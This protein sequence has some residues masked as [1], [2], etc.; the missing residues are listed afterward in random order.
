VDDGEYIIG[1]EKSDDGSLIVSKQHK[2]Y[3]VSFTGDV[4]D[5][6][7]VKAISGQTGALSHWSMVQI[8]EGVFYLSERGPQVVVG[9]ESHPLAQTAGIL[10]MFEFG[11]STGFNISSLFYST[12]VNDTAR[13]TLFVTV[14]SNGSTLRDQ[15]LC[16][17]YE[18]GAFHLRDGYNANFLAN[19]AQT[20]GFPLLSY[21]T[22]DGVVVRKSSSVYTNN[23][24]VVSL[25]VITPEWDMGDPTSTKEIH[26]LWLGGKV[27]TG[28][29]YVD[30]YVDGASSPNK[31]LT[32]DTSSSEWN[33]GIKKPV[34]VVCRTI[35][36]GLRQDDST[37]E[38][39]IDYMVIDYD[40]NGVR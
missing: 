37:S 16:Y 3:K 36:I 23:G 1:F 29:V 19:L 4:N 27:S 22:N 2:C 34:G 13:N 17:D 20:N 31:T 40:D 9:T 12:A 8:P 21:G 11:S 15:I 33:L 6:Y 32:F 10:D 25:N 39:Q 30:I 14:A 38:L 24:N 5:P 26:W 18:A 7:S 28:T 35:K